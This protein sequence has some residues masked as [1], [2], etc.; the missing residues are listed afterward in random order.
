[1]PVDFPQRVPHL[2]YVFFCA[3][4]QSVTDRRL[5]G[6]ARATE[7]HR[8]RLVGSHPGICLMQTMT[9]GHDVDERVLQFFRGCVGYHFLFYS[10][11]LANHGP[12]THLLNTDA[13]HGQAGTW[14]KSDMIVHGDSFP[15]ASWIL[16][17]FL[18]GKSIAFSHL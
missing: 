2:L 8:Q 4:I 13:G 10:D 5:F 9:A 7:G 11:M 18:A 3:G 1:M 14:R 17:S 16:W 15:L 12:D 6:A